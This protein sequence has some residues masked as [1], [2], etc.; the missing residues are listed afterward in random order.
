MISAE[1]AFLSA[2]RFLT[3]TDVQTE[4]LSPTFRRLRLSYTVLLA[5]YTLALVAFVQVRLSVL[6]DYS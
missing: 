3:H 5:E 6:T 4:L 2:S 1:R